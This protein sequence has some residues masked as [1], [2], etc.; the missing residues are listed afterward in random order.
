VRI[1]QKTLQE[2]FAADKKAIEEKYAQQL[3]AKSESFQATLANERKQRVEVWRC[4]VCH[5]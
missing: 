3:K 5:A 2:K 1:H 4:R